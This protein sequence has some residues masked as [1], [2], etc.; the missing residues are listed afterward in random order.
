MRRDISILAQRNRVS[1]SD[2]APTAAMARESKKARVDATSSAS[3]A[4]T[5]AALAI[6]P[7]SLPDMDFNESKVEI[8]KWAAETKE[9]VDGA[10]L[11]FLSARSKQVT[12]SVPS[13]VMLI[14]PW[15]SATQPLALI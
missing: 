2:A 9:Y 15:I 13:S 3:G 11:T 4:R 7:P 5:P 14:P 10:L 12:F 6:P 1:L 8:L